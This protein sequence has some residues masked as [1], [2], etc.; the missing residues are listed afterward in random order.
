MKKRIWELDFLRGFSIILM[1]FD[2]MMYDLM[3]MSVYFKNF[4]AINLPAFNWLQETAVKYWIWDIR[5]FVHYFI[6]AIFLLVSGISFTFSRNNLKRGTKFLVVALLISLF[7]YVFQI[8]SGD[9]TFILIGIIHMYA[10]TT[11]LT[12]LIRRIWNNDIFIMVL[13]FVIIGLG[14]S[15]QYW[16]VDFTDQLNMSTLPRIIYGSL[17]YG[18]DYF[19]IVPYLGFIMLGTVI[20]NIFYKNRVSLVPTDKIS[21]K[22]IFMFAGRHSLGIFLAHQ[23]VLFGLLWVVGLIF[24]YRM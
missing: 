12:F 11:L 13:A 17:G 9:N 14:F 4:T 18:A 16:H 21:E 10:L 15:F 6:I 1:V 22:N 24:G 3:N 19:G 8:T 20:G 2:H 7:T 23:F 5:T